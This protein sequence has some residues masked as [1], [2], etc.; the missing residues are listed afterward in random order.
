[1]KTFAGRVA[2]VTGAGSGIGLA[3]AERFGR[4][5]MNVVL[6][7]V[8]V[9]R[10]EE[11]VVRVE[12]AGA[13]GAVGI[14]TDVRDPDA[15][16]SL[17]RRA[18]ETY[19][20]VHLLCNNA[21]VSAIGYLWQTPLEDWRWVLD[22]NLLGIVNGLRSFVPLLLEQ[23][24]AHVVNTASMAAFVTSAGMGAYIAS[25]HGAVGVSKAL[26]AD[27]AARWPH[28]GVTVVCP[29]AVAT[30]LA[31]N[32]RTPG[33]PQDAARVDALRASLEGA[34]AA[35]DV[36]EMVVATVLAGRFWVFPDGGAHVAALEAEL[37]ELR[38]D[39]DR[40]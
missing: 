20:G 5:G 39:V 9:E 12:T 11:A 13:S 34:F 27:L 17:A 30:N 19:G 26:R 22:V 1:M 14:V 29:G 18:V 24:E 36:A 23:D 15:V 32:V 4:E 2:V 21:G 25:K 7:D 8:S 40:S 16:E 28:V 3:L 38:R 31:D 35:A 37:A 6:A 10:L 33:R